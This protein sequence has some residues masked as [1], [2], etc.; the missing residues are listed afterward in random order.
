MLPPQTRPK[1]YTSAKRPQDSFHFQFRSFVG[2]DSSVGIATGLQTRWE[3]G[4]ILG[5]GKIF[6][7]STASR[8]AVRPTQSPILWV[9]G[10]FYLWV[11]RQEREADH[12]PPSRAEVKNGRAIP[13]YYRVFQTI[14]N[15]AIS[16]YRLK[17]VDKKEILRTVSNTGV[18]CSSDKVGTVYL[19]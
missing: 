7:F 14:K 17:I 11:K 13:L 16:L 18:Y 1:I 6:L 8:P 2:R 15:R 4:S 5:R 9:L 19:V 12:S 3:Q 10:D